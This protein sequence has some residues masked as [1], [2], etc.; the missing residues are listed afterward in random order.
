MP[1]LE[2]ALGCFSH[3]ALLVQTVTPY[4]RRPHSNFII[5]Q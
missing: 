5:A 1:T 2:E 3:D 4:A